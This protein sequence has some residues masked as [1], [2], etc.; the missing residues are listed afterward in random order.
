MSS[1]NLARIK[2]IRPSN[3]GQFTISYPLGTDGQL[4]DMLSGLDLEEQLR[5]GSNHYITILEDNNTTTIKE[6]YFSEAMGNRNIQTMQNQ[7]LITY[8]LQTSITENIE[9]K[10]IIDHQDNFIDTNSDIAIQDL[11]V[12][13]NL[14]ETGNNLVTN[15]SIKLFKG[16]IK[17]E[18]FTLQLIHSKKIQIAEDNSQTI[19]DE[20]LISNNQEGEQG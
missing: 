11:L 13:R 3:E 18:N 10:Y 15:I 5:I 2:E 8:Y 17:N 4:V 19:I 12:E 6:W 14:N 1:E 7:K 9:E 20:Q 16:I